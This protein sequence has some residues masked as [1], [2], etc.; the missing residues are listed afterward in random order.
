MKKI[1]KEELL[2]QF[3][4]LPNRFSE[5]MHGRKAENFAVM[6]TYGRELFVRCYHRYSSGKIEERQRYV[7]ANDGSVRY[8]SDD[9]KHWNIRKDF[10]EPVFCKSCYDFDNSYHLLNRNAFKNSCMKYSGLEY[11]HGS[12]VMDYLHLYCKHRNLEYLMKTG[13]DCVLLESCNGFWGGQKSLSLMTGI[14]W[15]SNN[16]LKMLGLNRTEFKVLQG[17][18]ELYPLYLR[19]K[20]IFPDCTPEELLALA[21]TFGYSQYEMQKFC[22]I[23]ETKPPRL[24]LYLSGQNICLY[25]YR[26]YLEQC[27]KLDYNLHDT[28]ISMPHHF[29]AMHTRLTE[30]IQY[31]ADKVHEQHLKERISERKILEFQ[32]GKLLI[33]QP[34]SLNEIIDEG[35]R[36]CHCVGGYARRHAEGILHILFLRRISNPETPYYTMEVSTKGKIVQCRGYKNNAIQTGGTP[37]PPEIEEF[38]V[39]YQKY[40]DSLYK[41]R[42]WSHE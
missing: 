16:M 24:A 13:Y 33:C 18:E 37:K 15:E 6:L 31:K 2:R 22:E 11:Y 25:D 32:S 42:E 34:K 29:I 26:D 35:R 14:D 39:K 30:I 4:A 21:G 9:G 38:E 12:L 41:E 23:T 28:A 3:P 1:R 40:L 8:G 20:E 5:E 19:W 27:R 17:H 36:L 7:F 10:R